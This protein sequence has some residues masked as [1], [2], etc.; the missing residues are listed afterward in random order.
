MRS[1][2]DS[3][4]KEGSDPPA[5]MGA[6]GSLPSAGIKSAAAVPGFIGLAPVLHGIQDG[7]EAAPQLSQSVLHAGRDLRIHCAGKQAAGL[8]LPKLGGQHLLADAADGAL[9][10]AE[11]LSPGQ[12]VPK[13]E[14]LSLDADEGQSGLHRA[15]GEPIGSRRHKDPS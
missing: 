2:R 4:K 11:A 15:G 1:L 5:P 14:D 7:F 13:D 6:G 3:C 9:Q 12:Q 8:H 10:F